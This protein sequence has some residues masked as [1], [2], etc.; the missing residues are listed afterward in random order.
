M[1]AEYECRIGTDKDMDSYK[2]RD[3]NRQMDRQIDDR[4]MIER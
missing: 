1:N 2:Q 4:K 3:M